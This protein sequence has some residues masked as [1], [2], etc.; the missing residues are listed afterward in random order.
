M[1]APHVT[2]VCSGTLKPLEP[3]QELTLGASGRRAILTLGMKMGPQKLADRGLLRY[4]APKMVAI[5]PEA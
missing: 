5:L 2:V 3:R 4:A 1:N